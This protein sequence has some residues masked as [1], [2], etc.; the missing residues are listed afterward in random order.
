MDILRFTSVSLRGAIALALAAASATAG[1]QSAPSAP[2]TGA[3]EEVMVTATRRESNLQS[4]PIA[5]S[6]IDQH[7][8]QQI[9]PET[10]SDL[11][12][13]VPN[14]SAT[15]VTALMPPPSPCAASAR[16]TSSCTT[17]PP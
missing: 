9:S 3:L 8:I 15:K 5:V 12:A 17:K 6:A 13:Y 14:F 7:L 2:A 4:T 1:A 10:I 11:A 16:P